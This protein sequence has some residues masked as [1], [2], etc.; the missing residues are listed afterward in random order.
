MIA[1]WEEKHAHQL[2]QSMVTQAGQDTIRAATTTEEA[3]TATVEKLEE[4]LARIYTN[5]REAEAAPHRL[6]NRV[7]EDCESVQEYA[8][9]VRALSIKANPGMGP[10]LVET[11]CERHFRRGLCSEMHRTLEIIQKTGWRT[12]VQSAAEQDIIIQQE[13]TTQATANQALIAEE[14]STKE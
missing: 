4:L 2:L 13:K 8:V 1:G 14:A 10:A 3:S 12:V 7:R 6:Q 5:P 9:A 11:E